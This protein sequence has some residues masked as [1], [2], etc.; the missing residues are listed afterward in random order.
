MKN[1]EIHIEL[2]LKMINLENDY[3]VAREQLIKNYEGI[4]FLK[5]GFYMIDY[6]LESRELTK[7]EIVDYNVSV[8][9]YDKNQLIGSISYYVKGC[10]D[11]AKTER[12]EYDRLERYNPVEVAV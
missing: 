3:T 11:G 1:Q 12:I 2:R 7:I 5:R 4:L 6:G 8:N 10:F 9:K